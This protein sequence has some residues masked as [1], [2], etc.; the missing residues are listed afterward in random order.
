MS[1][2]S[3]V[4]LGYPAAVLRLILQIRLGAEPDLLN[5]GGQSV[6]LLPSSSSD[7]VVDAPPPTT[8]GAVQQQAMLCST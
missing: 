5:K 4:A 1:M 7:A 8:G 3:N 2:V 6:R